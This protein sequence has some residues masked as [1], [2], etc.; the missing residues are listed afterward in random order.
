M[1]SKVDDNS[2]STAYAIDHDIRLL[3]KSVL[4]HAMHIVQFEPQVQSSVLTVLCIISIKSCGGYHTFARAL[5]LQ[6]A[7]WRLR[8]TEL[9]AAVVQQPRRAIL[10]AW[11]VICWGSI[12][13]LYM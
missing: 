4:R 13:S 1:N 12:L 3:S 2:A 8:F 7:L 11:T 6:V 5:G 10:T 9:A